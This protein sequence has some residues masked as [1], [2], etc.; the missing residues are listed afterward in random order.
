M[1][2][3]L[4]LGGEL[5]LPQLPDPAVPDNACTGTDFLLHADKT[6]NVFWAMGWD[7]NGWASPAPWRC[8]RLSTIVQE[9][10]KATC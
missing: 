3:R 7:K 4:L 2:V 8:R 1:P 5:F 9:F 6:S 10:V